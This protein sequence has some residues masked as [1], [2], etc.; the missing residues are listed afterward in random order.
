MNKLLINICCWFIPKKKNRRHFRE[1]Y[2]RGKIGKKINDT[3]NNTAR[4]LKRELERFFYKTNV[5]QIKY[6]KIIAVYHKPAELFANDCIVPVHGGR[7][8]MT[9]T[10]TTRYGTTKNNSTAQKWLLENTIGDNTGQNLSKFNHKMGPFTAFYWVRH[11][12]DKI[13]NPE[14]IGVCNY[15]KFFHHS[16]LSEYL[17]YDMCLPRESL[18]NKSLKKQF[19]KCHPQSLYDVG[20]NAVKKIYPFEFEKVENFFELQW[21]YFNEMFVLRRDL[22][23]EIVDFISPIAIEMEK[24]ISNDER[25]IVFFL[26]RIEAWWLYNKTQEGVSYKKFEKIDWLL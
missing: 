10:I 6:L 20:M 14:Y 5:E 7:E 13:D 23:F 11:N 1:K 15:S 24:Q 17:N 25:N 2:G 3:D 26:E 4:Y 19:L 21:G 16:M 22:F 8:C 9:K 12:M 18:F